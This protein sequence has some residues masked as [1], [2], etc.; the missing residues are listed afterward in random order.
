MF[1]I[2]SLDDFDLNLSHKGM[3]SVTL[4]VDIV[5]AMEEMMV[6]YFFL[7]FFFLFFFWGVAFK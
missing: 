3:R 6:V 4:L 1:Y 2:I 5:N 7:S